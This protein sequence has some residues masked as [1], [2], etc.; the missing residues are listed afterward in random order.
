M[1]YE[2]DE[3]KRRSNIEKHGIDFADLPPLFQGRT[4]IVKDD[5][6]DYGEI[7]FITLGWLNGEVL[8]VA[9]TETD[10]VIRII[11]ARK[12]T[13]YEEEQYFEEIA[14]ELGTFEEDEG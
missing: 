3:R 6:F 1:G 2:W 5:R 4:V 9:H 10:E 12:A 14:N 8:L 11:S 7:R 13:S